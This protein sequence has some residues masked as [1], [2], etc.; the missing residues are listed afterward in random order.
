MKRM[1]PVAD[2]Y[3]R[4]RIGES[5]TRKNSS[6]SNIRRLRVVSAAL[7]VIAMSFLILFR[8]D[9]ENRD[10][11]PHRRVCSNAGRPLTKQMLK[12]L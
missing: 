11:A 1:A 10:I 7:A 12:P 6:L 5:A 9:A 2:R 8:A 4:W 3:L